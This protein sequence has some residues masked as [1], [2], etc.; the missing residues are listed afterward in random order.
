[1]EMIGWHAGLR[2]DRFDRFGEAL[3]VIRERCGHLATEVFELWQKLL[4]IVSMLRHRFMSHQDAI[5]LLLH[6]HHT[7]VRAPWIVAITMTLRSRRD[8]KQLPQALLL[9]R[10]IAPISS[11][12]S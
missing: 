8:G 7:V 2:I 9:T 5:M 12:I 10:Q 11:S 1:M 4:G 6:H 3:R